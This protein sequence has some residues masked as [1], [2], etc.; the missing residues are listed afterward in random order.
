[1]AASRMSSSAPAAFSS[2]NADFVELAAS[3]SS[4]PF[5][6]LPPTS[7][8]LTPTSPTLMPEISTSSLWPARVT[9]SL[10]R[11]MVI[12]V[13]TMLA[14]TAHTV[15]VRTPSTL[16]MTIMAGVR[17]R[18][19]KYDAAPVASAE[20]RSTHASARRAPL[21]TGK[22]TSVVAS[23]A[24]RFSSGSVH[25]PRRTGCAAGAS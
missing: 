4:T 9:V 22:V 5:G 25:R 14:R 24:L 2:A 20:A 8:T 6:G 10:P 12:S 23:T 3:A 15:R 16:A 17:S 1:M 13:V 7:G 21:R 19:A 11:R 18:L